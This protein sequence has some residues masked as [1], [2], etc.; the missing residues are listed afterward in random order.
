M[1]KRGREDAEKTAHLSLL[2]RKNVLLQTFHLMNYI[3][4][5]KKISN[6]ES[7]IYI[8][9]DGYNWYNDN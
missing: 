5:R 2:V 6:I 9:W 7:F 8:R 3:G 1:N 4:R